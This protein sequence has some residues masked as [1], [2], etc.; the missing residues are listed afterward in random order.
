MLSH[1]V[2]P[3]S[4]VFLPY[5]F[6]IRVLIALRAMI[7]FGLR[8]TKVM[9]R[10]ISSYY[11]FAC[12]VINLS[13]G[14]KGSISQL[15]RI[16]HSLINTLRLHKRN[17]HAMRNSLDMWLSNLVPKFFL[18]MRNLIRCGI[19]ATYR[20]INIFKYSNLRN[21]HSFFSRGHFLQSSS[22]ALP[23]FPLPSDYAIS[24]NNRFQFTQKPPNPPIDPP[25]TVFL[26]II[27]IDLIGQP[28]KLLFQTCILPTYTPVFN[29]IA[30]IMRPITLFV[31]NFLNFL[32]YALF[33]IP[34]PSKEL[35]TS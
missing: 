19:S 17:L 18:D 23:P 22:V 27:L 13:K 7:P 15:M 29:L 3:S 16:N 1:A 25:L 20:N 33:A 28:V 10:F 24:R 32:D 34:T 11:D 5:L 30:R 21:K 9:H 26:K 4:A 14:A 8:S 2:Q 35:S 12:H 6:I 31:R